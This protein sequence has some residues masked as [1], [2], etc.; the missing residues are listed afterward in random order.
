LDRDGPDAETVISRSA[1]APVVAG[2]HPNI[3][4]DDGIVVC[5]FDIDF[6]VIDRLAPSKPSRA[7][8]IQAR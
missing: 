4:M 2:P 3:W 7:T 5:T 6:T 8:I 1:Q